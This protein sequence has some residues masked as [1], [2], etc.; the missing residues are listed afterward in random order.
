MCYNNDMNIPLPPLSVLEERYEYSI[1]TGEV[2]HKA[3]ATNRVKAGDVITRLNANGYIGTSV[4][5]TQYL[6]ARIIWKLVTGDDPG[7][8]TVEHEDRV[9]TNN[10]WHNLT[11]KNMPQQAQNKQFV[12]ESP[13]P[14]YVSYLKDRDK[15]QVIKRR[16][17]KVVHSSRH[18]TLEEATKVA[19]TL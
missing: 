17:G 16:G 7:D 10:A 6:L 1:I 8:L 9:R 19:S 12:I 4:D 15:F 3:P 14:L 18:N 13:Y 5:G 11:L 2:R